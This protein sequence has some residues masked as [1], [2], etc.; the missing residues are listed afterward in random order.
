MSPGGGQYPAESLGGAEHRRIR[1]LTLLPGRG[2]LEAIS[3]TLRTVNLGNTQSY[4]ALSY[5]WGDGGSPQTI[6]VNGTDFHVGDNLFEALRH[7]RLPD[8]ERVLWIDAIC[9]NQSNLP[10]RNS[11]VQLMADVYSQAHQ[12]IAWIGLE[13]EDSKTAFKFLQDAFISSPRNRQ[14]IKDDPGWQGVDTL[15]QRPYWKRVWIVQEICL[16]QRLTVKCGLAQIPWKYL[17]VLRVARKH[18]WPQYHS[19]GERVFM[20][21]TPARID[22]QRESRRKKDGCGL[23]ALLEAFQDSMCR[24]VHDRVYGFI[25]L[26]SD[27][28]GQSIPADYSKSVLQLYEDVM[29]F[30]RDKFRAQMGSE[31]PPQGPQL[32]RLSEFLHRLLG[33]SLEAESVSSLSRRIPESLMDI[34]ATRM[35]IIQQFLDAD[36]AEKYRASELHDFLQG[37]IPYS[38]LGP[39]RD[40]VSPGVDEVHAIR[41]SRAVLL[42]RVEIARLPIQTKQV[43][44]TKMPFLA[45]PPR[46]SYNPYVVDHRYVVGVA[47]EG[48]QLGD[49]VCTF[50]A[51]RLALVFRPTSAIS[52]PLMGGSSSEKPQG[53]GF[54]LVGRAVVDLSSDEAGQPF[55][56]VLKADKTV[57]TVQTNGNPS[58]A[59][60]APWP[61]TVSVDMPTLRL[62]TRAE[63]NP[64]S[65]GFAKAMLNLLPQNDLPAVLGTA[66]PTD[67]SPDDQNSEQRVQ[68]GLEVQQLQRDPRLLKHALG[69]GT[70]GILN[71]GATGYLSA[72]LQIL[73]MLKPLRMDILN[74]PTVRDSGATGAA[75]HDL[76]THLRRSTLPVSPE[77]LTMAFGWGGQEVQDFVD[78]FKEFATLFRSERLGKMAQNT[79]T[80]LFAGKSRLESTNWSGERMSRV[81]PFFSTNCNPRALWS[82]QFYADANGEA[83]IGLFAFGSNTLEDALHKHL[84][85]F[86]DDKT[87]FLAMPPVLLFDL[88]NVVYNRT[89]ATVE[90]VRTKF[91]YPRVLDMTSAMNHDVDN[92]PSDLIYQLHG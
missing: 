20:R 7:L 86:G 70:A 19:Q 79:Y 83:G 24:E 69:P 57:E 72:A 76:F 67:A 44:T 54:A 59:Q 25:G 30:H 50:L 66:A 73:Y 85:G 60:D 2:E 89:T 75:L 18:I 88:N 74:D 43:L 68:D 77:A 12:V 63:A 91:T 6:L 87:D 58:E 81:E 61:A 16:A 22:Y 39:W 21:S 27:C 15:C 53:A 10:E 41:G 8:T 9:I 84:A 55:Q 64:S 38:H 92:S 5:E 51:S 28:D 34:S 37:R 80:D 13:T 46:Q 11:Q 82:R 23:W 3:C 17:S 49:V 71:L 45:H 65:Q 36:L 14:S 33:P 48:T 1:L 42:S 78:F 47:P 40:Y 4:E 32:V 35:L 52:S 90:R 29:R 26:S 31:G 62:V 56:I